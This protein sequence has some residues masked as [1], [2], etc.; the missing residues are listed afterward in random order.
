M[1][2]PHATAL[3][4]L[5]CA[6]GSLVQ[7]LG[8]RYHVYWGVDIS[9]FAVSQARANVLAMTDRRAID[10]DCHFEAASILEFQPC[11]QF[12]VIAF[13]EVLYY[14]PL[15]QI[16]ST[17]NRYARSLTQD[18]IIL[19]SL[20]HDAIAHLVQSIAM[21][22]LEFVCGVLWQQ[23]TERPRWKV[24]G[25]RELPAALIHVFRKNRTLESTI[26]SSG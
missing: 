3:L 22:E 18:G 4:D 23:Q 11:R 9:A 12:D 24:I 25:N 15:N 1:I 10:F 26:S 6:G 19:V 7:R 2:A 13:N 14:L 20:K 8:P 5:G 16:E 21:R 17:L